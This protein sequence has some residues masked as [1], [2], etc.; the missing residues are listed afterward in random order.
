MN[1]ITTTY[2]IQDFNRDVLERSHTVP[3]IVDFWAEWCGP[4]KVL[5]P[6]LER[7]AEKSKGRWTLAKVDTD[8]HQ[9]LAARYGIRG[10][11]SVKLFVDGNVANEFTGALPEPM[12]VQWLERALPGTF[13]KNIEHAE[14]LIQNGN[15]T[16]A[17]VVLAG[18]LA[19]EPENFH[20][21]VL[22][23]KNLVFSYPGKAQEL[24]EGIEEDSEHFQTVD[25]IRTIVELRGKKEHPETLPEDPVREKYLEAIGDLAH[26]EY[27]IALRKF[28]DLIRANRLYDDDG[29]RKAVIA[30]F[31]ILGDESEI[32]LKHRRDFGSA[33]NV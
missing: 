16:E 24:I 19:N 15:L 29:S 17:N 10:I 26:Q 33:L 3:V 31:R 28:I 27:D 18:V 11:P 12:V 23:A 6:I 1:K 4:C 8:A 7:L 5:G 14:Q 32:A 22:L 21:R 2:E 13:R 30:I 20:A 9:D 25:A